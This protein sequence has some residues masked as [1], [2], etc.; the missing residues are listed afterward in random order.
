MFRILGA[1]DSLPV[2][3]TRGGNTPR[4]AQPHF[5]GA[6]LVPKVELDGP[7]LIEGAVIEPE[8][9]LQRLCDELLLVERRLCLAGHRSCIVPSSFSGDTAHAWLCFFAGLSLRFGKEDW[10]VNFSGEGW[11][12]ACWGRDAGMWVPLGRRCDARVTGAQPWRLQ[13][14]SRDDLTS[15]LNIPDSNVRLQ[16][17]HNHNITNLTPSQP[18]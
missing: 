16:H 11:K 9:L 4:L 3:E 7:V 10:L 14:G 1:S 15:V 2:K 5:G 8:V 18:Q 12:P 6:I 17:S 13:P